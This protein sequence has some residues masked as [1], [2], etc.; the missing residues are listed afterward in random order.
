MNGKINSQY[1]GYLG[2]LY[3]AG[4]LVMRGATVA[5]G[6]KGSDQADLVLHGVLPVEIKTARPTMYRKDLKR[7]GYQFCLEREGHSEMRGEFLILVC[8]EM[9]PVDL[10]VFIIPTFAI[11]SQGKITI[12][13]E[14]PKNY[15]GKWAKWLNRWDLITGSVG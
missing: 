7:N 13:Q 10:D 14:N 11:N 9:P 2:E 3:A 12:P 8:W 1:L 4:E 15:Q 5:R 6:G